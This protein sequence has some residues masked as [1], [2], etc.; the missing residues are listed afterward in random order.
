MLSR[1]ARV[2]R[3]RLRFRSPLVSAALQ[4]VREAAAATLEKDREAE[5][6]IAE[7]LAR[8]ASDIRRGQ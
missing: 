7:I 8:A 2:P 1:F 6:R 3:H 5:A 4:A